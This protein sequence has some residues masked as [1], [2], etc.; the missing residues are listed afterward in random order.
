[1]PEH[2]AILKSKKKYLFNLGIGWKRHGHM[3]S[4]VFVLIIRTITLICIFCYTPLNPLNI[5]K[6]TIIFYYPRIKEQSI[7]VLYRALKRCMLLTRACLYR[8]VS[9]S[10]Q[11]TRSQKAS[12]TLVIL[13]VFPKHIFLRGVLQPPLDYTEYI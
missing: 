12:L 11:C 1:M 3:V 4:L 10:W 7:F 9:R 2:L 6:D 5:T 8:N 13:R